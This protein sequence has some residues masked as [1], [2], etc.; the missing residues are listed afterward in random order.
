MFL[1]S[2]LERLDV[3][4][5]KVA[6]LAQK[7]MILCREVKKATLQAKIG[8]IKMLAGHALWIHYM[9]CLVG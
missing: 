4:L 1:E 2:N 3:L 6:T 7:W 5:H 8:E 9:V